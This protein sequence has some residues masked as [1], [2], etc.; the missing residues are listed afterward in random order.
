MR[1]DVLTALNDATMWADASVPIGNYQ[2]YYNYTTL[3]ALH[4][5]FG[6]TLTVHSDWNERK[7][8]TL[9][10]TDDRKRVE[11]MQMRTDVNALLDLAWNSTGLLMDQ[12]DKRV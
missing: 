1:L 8:Y 3:H 4:A 11:F 7:V 10:L 2:R 12:R 9:M 5:L 6:V